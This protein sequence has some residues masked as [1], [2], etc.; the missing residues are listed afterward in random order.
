MTKESR[1]NIKVYGNC[2]DCGIVCGELLKEKIPFEHIGN[3]LDVVKEAEAMKYESLPI[4][5]IDDEMIGPKLSPVEKIKLIKRPTMAVTMAT[6]KKNSLAQAARDAESVANVL[7]DI[8]HIQKGIQDNR[9]EGFVAGYE[10]AIQDV[11][12]SLTNL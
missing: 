2:R 1:V 9:Y 3:Y 5:I 6:H 4:I 8:P 12:A 11:K 7:S 10:K